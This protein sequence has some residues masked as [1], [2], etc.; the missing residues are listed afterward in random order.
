MN[1]PAKVQI[2]L[3]TLL[4]ISMSVW[5]MGIAQTLR[6]YQGNVVIAH[7]V[8]V[9]D[10]P[11]HN[12]TTLSIGTATY[13]IAN[14]DSICGSTETVDDNSVLIT[15]SGNSAQVTIAA[16]VAPMLTTTIN[17]AHV[18]I[19]QS[20]QLA[21]EIT[22]TLQGTS[23]N[24]SFGMDGNLKASIMLNN[25]SLTCADSAAINI[26]DSK[27]I[28]VTLADGTTNT[29]A[30]GSAGSQKACFMVKG[31][32][33]FKG[34]GSLTL[35]GHVAHG[36]WGGEYVEF[37]KSLGSITIAS[38]VKDGFNVN[39]YLEVKGGT[40]QINAVGDDGI[41]VSKTDDESDEQNGQV[42]ISGG[43]LNISVSAN[44]AKGIKCDDNFTMSNGTLNIST[45][46]GGMYDSATNDVSASAAIKVG[47]NTTIDG[48]NITLNSTGAGGKGLN[49]SNIV[50]INNGTIS[51]STTGKQYSYNRQSSSAKGIR[52]EG[53][54]YINGGDV[55]VTCSGGEGAEGIE[56]KKEIHITAGDITSICYDDAVNAA[57]KIDISGGR[58]YAY[59][60]NNDG[61]D[62]NGTLYISGGVVIANGTSQPEEGFDCDQNTFSVTGGTLIGIGGSTSIPTS[63]ATT[64]P[65]LILGGLSFTQ[66]TYLCLSDADGNK[67]WTYRIPRSINQAALLISSPSL[68]QGSSCTLTT[69]VSVAEAT[70]WNGYAIDGIISGGNTLATSQ[71]TSI[72]TSSGSLS[73][74]PGGGGGQPGGGG[75]RPGGRW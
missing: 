51:V 26:R 45:T 14:I 4:F 5:Q 47:G 8:T 18:S 43:T 19:V 75:G 70:E 34:A 62:S 39:Q 67:V 38:A 37:K 56:S 63:T 50:T 44:A 41:Q 73:G 69:G 9:D 42:L 68:K 49:C 24:G 40:L 35:T 31:H 61:I 1:K 25:L 21:N 72:V 17:G 52:A 30:D 20:S 57:S 48:G 22:Y 64:Q 6:V 7:N 12:G 55:S 58:I 33:E 10:I 60:S 28:S 36:F 71:L 15:Y 59:A 66:N 32:T 2:T 54:L 53:N 27:R 74:Q 13:N 65:V 46:G 3:F 16:N 11:F 23:S 29:L